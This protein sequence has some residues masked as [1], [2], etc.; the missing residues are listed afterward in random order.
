[1]KKETAEC[2][3]TQAVFLL[4]I[5]IQH[6]PRKKKAKYAAGSRRDVSINSRLCLGELI[7]RVS[8]ASSLNINKV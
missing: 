7:Y 2:F 5:S 6:K 3:C 4:F 1:M 8:G